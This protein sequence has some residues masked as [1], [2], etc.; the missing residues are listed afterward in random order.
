MEPVSDPVGTARRKHGAAGAILAAGMF[1][2][3]IALGRKPKEEV[4]VVVDAAGEPGDLDTD[5]ISIAVDSATSVVTPA[6]PRT[7]PVVA[8]P[9]RRRA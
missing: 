7:V 2:V 1:G 3:D 9:R 6:L 8:V 5:G 4:P